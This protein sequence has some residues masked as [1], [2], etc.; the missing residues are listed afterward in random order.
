MASKTSFSA[1]VYWNIDLLNG[2]K[3]KKKLYFEWAIEK[4]YSRNI[5]R[6]YFTV[7]KGRRTSS[8]NFSK[9]EVF[10]K[11]IILLMGVLH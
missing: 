5:W 7:Y 10:L 4:Y 11:D 8:L 3:A 9:Y 6:I 1:L 2:D